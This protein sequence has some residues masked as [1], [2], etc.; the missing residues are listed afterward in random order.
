MTKMA[1]DLRSLCR[2]YTETTVRTVAGIAQKG[3]KDSDK[4][5]AIA[6]LWE[7]GWG[8]PVQPHAGADGEGDIRVTIRNIING[9]DKS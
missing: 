5:T 7:R 3:P 4:L 8:K 2:S 6:M 1:A 9:E